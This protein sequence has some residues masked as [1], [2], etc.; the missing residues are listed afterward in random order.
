MHDTL[1]PMRA[2]GRLGLIALRTYSRN[3]A[4]A[5]V[6]GRFRTDVRRECRTWPSAGET[7]YV[8]RIGYFLSSEESTPAELVE[9][10][11]LA[12]HAGFD[13]LRIS[14]HYHPWNADR[15]RAQ[16]ARFA[17]TAHLDPARQRRGSRKPGPGGLP[18]PR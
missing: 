4:T 5:T 11:Q 8:V 13:A 14:D 18:G 7:G 9:Q 6:R 12:E 10:A 16:C 15:V 3:V 17:A 1:I 2:G